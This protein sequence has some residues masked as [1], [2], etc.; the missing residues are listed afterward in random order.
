[1]SDTV[2]LLTSFVGVMIIGILAHMLGRTLRIPGI[3]FLLAA[4]IILGPE[5]TGLV[6]PEKFGNGIELIVGLSVAI[7]VFEGGL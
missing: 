5:V 2:Y 3:V 4:G 1:M 7:I 6:E